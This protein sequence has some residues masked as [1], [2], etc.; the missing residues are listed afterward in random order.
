MTIWWVI[1]NSYEGKG[2]KR[3]MNAQKIVDLIFQLKEE[4]GNGAET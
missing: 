4:A 3:R 1:Q 2:V